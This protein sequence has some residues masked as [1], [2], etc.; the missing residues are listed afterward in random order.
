MID[1]M[2]GQRYRVVHG[3]S[4]LMAVIVAALLLVLFVP[5]CMDLEEYGYGID[6][7]GDGWTDSQEATAG[8]NPDEVDSDSDGYWDPH[9]ANPLDPAITGAFTAPEPGTPPSGDITVDKPGEE[10]VQQ[11][12]E[13]EPEQTP[14]QPPPPPDSPEAAALDELHSVQEAVEVMMNNNGLTIL[15]NPVTEPTSNMHRFPDIITPH[16]TS[17]IGYV[18]YLHD[19]DGDGSPDT[20]YFPRKITSG[21]YVC[22]SSGHVTQVTTGY[23]E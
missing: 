14:Q 7:D 21:T 4:Q 12:P 19:Y 16:G 15:E 20:N 22:D 13:P 18:L 11:Q 5:S 9:D 3:R 10:T 2:T 17:G 8:T 23:E 6:T 1:T